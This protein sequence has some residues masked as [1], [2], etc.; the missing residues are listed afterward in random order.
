MYP[1]LKV[2]VNFIVETELPQLCGID[3]GNVRK[4]KALLGILASSVP[5]EVDISKL[6]GI[7]RS[8][9]IE[10]LNSLEKAKLLHLLYADL[11]SVKKKQKPDKIYLDNPNLLYDLASHPVKI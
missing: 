9:V 1:D 8:T 6:I 4:V 3:V 11:L 10:Y 2:V 5:F 7:H